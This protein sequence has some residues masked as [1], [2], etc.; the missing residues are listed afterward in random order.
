MVL[1]LFV[2]VFS[3]PRFI[4]RTFVLVVEILFLYFIEKMID[5]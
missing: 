3:F 1:F 4:D 2:V 5:L